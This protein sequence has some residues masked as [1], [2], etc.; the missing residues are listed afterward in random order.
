MQ[1]VDI[2]INGRKLSA[3]KNSTILEAAVQ[4]GIHIPTLCTLKGIDPKANCR[5]CVVEIERSRTFQP[6]CATKITEGMVINTDTPALRKSRKDTLELLLSRHSVDCHHCMRI[7][8]SKCDDLDPYFCEMC[9]F[10][11]CVRDGICELQALAREYKVDFLP[12]E[13]EDAYKYPL[14][15][16][17]ASVVRNP[18]K[19]I[20]CRRC[21][22]VCCEV[23]TVNALSVVNR[24]K[25]IQ[26][27]PEMEKKLIDSPCVQCGRCVSVCP[28]GAIY[29]KEQIDEL[30]YQAHSYDITTVAQISQDVLEGLATLSKLEPSQ[31]DICSVAAGLRKIGVNYIV[32]DEFALAASNAQAV[33]KITARLRTAPI[34]VTS[35][36]SAEKF[37]K[38]QFPDMYDRLVTYPSALQSFDSYIKSAWAA[39]KGIAPA[40]VR[41]ISITGTNESQAEAVANHSVDYVLN[42][43]ELYRIFLRTGVNL[44]KIIPTELDR[45]GTPAAPDPCFAEL[46][47]PVEWE[48]GSECRELMVEASGA[49]YRAA[50]G[51]TLGQARELLGKASKYEI[52]R[53]LA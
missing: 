52:I 39:Q 45:L 44:G 13:I 53:I 21:I 26:I 47:V 33:E 41:T 19:C 1:Q 46:L 30:I 23:Q 3:P 5:I 17:T 14:D 22:D 27:V 43:R 25:D 9:F 42:A 32:S 16:S 40:S 18:N 37:V 4:N 8:S 2:T 12:Y 29:E 24:G 20:K 28:T 35:S 48:I 11:D 7:G 38:T 10:C 50:V 51:T 15:E 34:I 31:L 49:S 6:A 36:Y